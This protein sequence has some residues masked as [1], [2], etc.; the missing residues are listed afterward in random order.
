MILAAGRMILAAG[1]MILAAGRMILAA[2]RVILATG[3]AILAILVFFAALLVFGTVFLA[4]MIQSPVGNHQ[5][6]ATSATPT[7]EHSYLARPPTSSSFWR[8][9]ESFKVRR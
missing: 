1:R 4:G 9:C 2:G 6:I 3:V 8:A 5:G 7:V